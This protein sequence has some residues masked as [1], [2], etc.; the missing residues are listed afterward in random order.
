[1]N[2]HTERSSILGIRGSH[3]IERE[4]EELGTAAAEEG[5]EAQ[6]EPVEPGHLLFLRN[7]PRPPA[8]VLFSREKERRAGKKNKRW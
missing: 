2:K 1:M 3:T 4:K 8:A 6:P 7:T 5:E